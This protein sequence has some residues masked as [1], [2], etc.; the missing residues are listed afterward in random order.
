MKRLLL[1]SLTAALVTAA[2]AQSADEVVSRV[3]A[4]QKAAKDISFKV[5]GSA[6]LQGGAQKFDLDVQTIPAQSLARVNFNAPDS[7][8][9]NVVVLDKNTIY[10]YLFLTNQVTVQTVNKVAGQ[11]GMS[12]DFSQ[13][14]DLTGSLK[15]RYDVKL[16]GTS[17]DGAGKLYQLE[18][19][20]KNGAGS[21]SRVWVSDQGWRPVRVQ[22]L[23]GSGQVA[24][25]LSISNY[26][27]N[28]G[29]SAAKLRALPK[30]AQI[31][32]R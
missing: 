7:L 8:A 21:R 1:A 2:S 28:A 16:V 11:A 9:D 27:V 23:Q 6:S 29:L 19:T 17:Q 22:V 12:L 25:D 15:A 10:N 26:K 31:V 24:A 13:V 20:P 14:T 32:K 4:A 5:T 30:D 18:A 3:D